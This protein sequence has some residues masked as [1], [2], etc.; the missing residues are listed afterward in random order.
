MRARALSPISTTSPRAPREAHH[1]LAV[2]PENTTDRSSGAARRLPI[3]RGPFFRTRPE[4]AIKAFSND[5]SP[6]GD[7]NSALA[8]GALNN[9][10]GRALGDTPIG[11]PRPS[12]PQN[13][14]TCT[15]A[16]SGRTRTRGLLAAGVYT[17]PGCAGRPSQ[18]STLRPV[19]QPACRAGEGYPLATATTRL[20]LPHCMCKL[21]PCEKAMPRP[22]GAQLGANV[23]E[24]ASIPR[25]RPR[26]THGAR[27]TVCH[28][29][30]GGSWPRA[31]PLALAL[32]PVSVCLGALQRGLG[33][34]LWRRGCGW[35]LAAL[36]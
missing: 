14:H 15:A 33:L 16:R 13:A 26:R 5:C 21:A 10:R 19:G 12:T 17:L 7:I 3:L 9:G 23:C 20:H 36:R 22:Y 28:G 32:G 2:T 24:R 4:R 25:D 29:G 1:Q 11:P 35:P 30:G 8:G 34:G 18:F 6:G 27:A 31:R